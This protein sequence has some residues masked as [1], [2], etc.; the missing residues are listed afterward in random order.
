MRK[1]SFLPVVFTLVMLACVL[2][3]VWYLPSVSICR[4]QLDDV[5]KSLETSQGRERKQQSEYDETVASIP[6]VEAELE[7]VLPLTEAVKEEVKALK[8]ERKALRKEKR[9]LE[10]SG[11][12]DPQEVAEND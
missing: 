12:S 9:E 7:R 5:R 8:K 1:Q 3:F 11:V 6:E 4:F 2:F 10:G